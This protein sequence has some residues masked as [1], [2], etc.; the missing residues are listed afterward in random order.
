[1]S[2]ADDILSRDIPLKDKIKAAQD[3][4]MWIKYDLSGPKEFEFAD[5]SQIISSFGGLWRAWS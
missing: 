4:A 2:E 5:G 3:K 1:M